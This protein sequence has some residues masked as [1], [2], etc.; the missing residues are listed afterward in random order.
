[1]GTE[2]SAPFS[3]SGK[4]EYFYLTELENSDVKSRRSSTSEF[5]H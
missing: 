4:A 1:M 2:A 5:L 3:C